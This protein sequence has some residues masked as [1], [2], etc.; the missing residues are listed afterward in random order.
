MTGPS[1]SARP[2]PMTARLGA[3]ALILEAF[4][5]LFATLVASRL[6]GLSSTTALAGGALVC[7]AFV[8]GAALVRR[9]GGLVVVGVLQVVLLATALVV[10]AMVWVGAVFVAL[11]WW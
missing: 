3:T 9:P 7:L 10:P 4:V 2:G 11:T 6:S 8:L 5:V 1:L